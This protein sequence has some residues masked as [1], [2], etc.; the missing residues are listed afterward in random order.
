LQILLDAGI[1][2]SQAAGAAARLTGWPRRMLYAW[3]TSMGA[4]NRNEEEADGKSG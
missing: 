3:A 4:A 2:P 1:A